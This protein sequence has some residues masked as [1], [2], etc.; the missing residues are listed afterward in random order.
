MAFVKTTWT[1][2]AV[3][4]MNAAQLNRIEQGIADAH[5]ALPNM[6]LDT[7]HSV[8]AA[9]EPAFQNGWVNANTGEPPL[10]FTKDPFGRVHLRGHITTGA[11]GSVIFTLPVGYRPAYQEYILCLQD[12]GAA[13]SFLLVAANGNVSGTRQ[14][15]GLYIASVNWSTT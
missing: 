6:P 4:R 11:S 13:G 12:T 1:D 15:A 7:W 14:Q 5:A 10:Q 9:G 2:R 8:G 3:P